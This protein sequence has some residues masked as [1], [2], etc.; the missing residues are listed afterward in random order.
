MED[1][2]VCRRCG[3]ICGPGEWTWSIG[4]RM[5]RMVP[6]CRE[7]RF[8]YEKQRK[9][10]KKQKKQSIGRRRRTDKHRNRKNRIAARGLTTCRSV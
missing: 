7:D 6:V 9:R 3:A 2:K 10:T 1:A 5:A 4:N 8:C